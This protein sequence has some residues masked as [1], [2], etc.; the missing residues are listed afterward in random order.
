VRALAV[1][2]ALLA[3]PGAAWCATHVVT[4]EGMVFEPAVLTVKR[5]DRVVWQNKDVV[6]H[7]VTAA[8]QFDSKLIAADARWSW[9]ARASGRHDYVCTFHPG[10][11]GTVVVAK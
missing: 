6:P 1:V 8:G 10:M 9:T 3:L 11:K 7:T 5:G 4:I 2:A